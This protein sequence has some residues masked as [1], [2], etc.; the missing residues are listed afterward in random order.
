MPTP[1][2]ELLRQAHRRASDNGFGCYSVFER[3]R[4]IDQVPFVEITDGN[5]RKFR[6]STDED[7]NLFVD[8]LTEGGWQRGETYEYPGGQLIFLF[9]EQNLKITATREYVGEGANMLCRWSFSSQVIASEDI[10]GIN[11]ES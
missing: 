9:E 5:G 2:Q 7:D 4:L 3:K 8:V 10:S 11:L 1:S 6:F